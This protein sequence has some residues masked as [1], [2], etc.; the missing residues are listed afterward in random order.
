MTAEKFGR[1]RTTLRPFGMQ[2]L[3]VLQVNAG[4]ETIA[5]VLIV[6]S[7]IPK[8]VLPVKAVEK[9]ERARRVKAKV[10]LPSNV[11][12]WDACVW[13]IGTMISALNVTRRQ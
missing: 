7:H 6:L 11:S 9:V 5:D 1:R 2:T 12:K 13:H 8:T 10:V 4:S 3:L